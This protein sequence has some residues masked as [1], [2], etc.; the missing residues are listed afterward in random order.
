VEARHG[1]FARRLGALARRLGVAVIQSYHDFKSAGRPSDLSRLSRQTEAD[2][3]KIAV[4]PK[5]AGELSRFLSWGL[6][7]EKIRRVLIAM[8]PEGTPSRTLAWSFG[9]VLAYGHLGVSA[10][11]GQLSAVDT[12]RAIR[13]IYG[14]RK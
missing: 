8:G 10:A 4:T 13:S 7:L 6:S 9:S 5:N 3:L 2:I 12:A 1:R 14:G 11:P